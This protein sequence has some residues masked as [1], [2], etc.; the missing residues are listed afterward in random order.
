MSKHFTEAMTASHGHCVYCKKFLLADFDTFWA[1]HE[2]HLYT[3]KHIKG[4]NEKIVMACGVCNNL[5]G[6]YLPEAWES[7]PEKELIDAIA[8]FIAQRRKAKEQDEYASWAVE[9]SEWA[10]NPGDSSDALVAEHG[11]TKP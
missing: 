2:D 5:R 1:S 10:G 6:D 3:R 9:K 7:M 11:A 8:E 4:A